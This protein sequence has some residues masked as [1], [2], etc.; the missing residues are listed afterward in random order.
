M[1]VIF[2]EKENGQ[3]FLSVKPLGSDAIEM[4]YNKRPWLS[5]TLQMLIKRATRGRDAYSGSSIQKQ[6]DEYEETSWSKLKD[7]M[8][9]LSSKPRLYVATSKYGNYYYLVEAGGLESLSCEILLGRLNDGYFY[10]ESKL[11]ALNAIKSNSCYNFLRNY[12]DEYFSFE[13]ESFNMFSGFEKPVDYCGEYL[14]V[15]IKDISDEIESES[16]KLK[17]SEISRKKEEIERLQKELEGK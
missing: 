17:E 11:E 1:S 15:K 13:E 10:K 2:E 6:F 3:W 9:K 4:Y 8:K 16:K 7:E 5:N 12:S 14:D